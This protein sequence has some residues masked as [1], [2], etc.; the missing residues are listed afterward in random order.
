M[1]EEEEV[2]EEEA[3]GRGR[4][5][6]R[7]KPTFDTNLDTFITCTVPILVLGSRNKSVKVQITAR[8]SAGERQR[9]K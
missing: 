2:E 5:R 3:L 9:V 7:K 8:A 4:E 1:D 6:E